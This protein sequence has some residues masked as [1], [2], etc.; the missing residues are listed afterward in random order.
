MG[1][2]DERIEYVTGLT[3]GDLH[4]DNVL[5]PRLG[6]RV[7]YEAFR[8]VDLSTFDAAA[9][10][11]SDLAM[12]A[13]SGLVRRF[14]DRSPGQNEALLHRLVDRSSAWAAG[15]S[16]DAV[17]LVDEVRHAARPSFVPA[18]FEEN[19]SEQL[20]LLMVTAALLHLSFPNVGAEAR[21]WL[22]RL[23]AHACTAFLEYSRTGTPTHRRRVDRHVVTALRTTNGD[24]SHR[25]GTAERCLDRQRR[26]S[27]VRTGR[28][29][30]PRR[31]RGNGGAVRHGR[32]G[33]QVVPRIGYDCSDA[34]VVRLTGPEE[35][36]NLIAE[37]LMRTGPRDA[38]A[39]YVTGTFESVETMSGGP[40]RTVVR[41]PHSR[42]GH[43][44][45]ALPLASL[46]EGFRERQ[47]RGEPAGA[48]LLV[49]DVEG[50]DPDEV[51]R[52][53]T[54]T[55][56]ALTSDNRG[57][58]VMQLVVTGRAEG[59]SDT[60]FATVW[61]WALTVADGPARDRPYLTHDDLAYLL[62]P[63]ARPGHLVRVVAP[64]RSGPNRALPNPR[65]HLVGVDPGEMSSGGSPR[66]VPRHSP[67]GRPGSSADAES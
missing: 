2:Q 36:R 14:S 54:A 10:L 57:P 28:R 50:T 31:G 32:I 37:R 8:L 9:P 18:E 45:G 23:A 43:D 11:G 35:P 64:A 53:A 42:A 39:M 17:A 41:T 59:G 55:M 63:E 24:T 20:L 52:E 19:W 60:S 49:L 22:F 1:G 44:R 12:L 66:R 30:R 56:S 65:H 58:E 46:L 51:A 5:V 27:P 67:R 7:G 47:R 29:T 15:M 3:H 61:S 16:P 34:D 38:V 33:A 40:R 62:R 48:L 25:P 4:E 21:W 26:L 6:K 13:V